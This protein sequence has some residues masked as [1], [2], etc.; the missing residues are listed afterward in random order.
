[1]TV[2]YPRNLLSD[3]TVEATFKLDQG[4]RSARHDSGKRGTFTRVFEPIWTAKFETPALTYAEREAWDAW[5]NSL[6]GG[7][8]KFLAWDTS[9]RELGAYPDGPPT[10][11][12]VSIS[13]FVDRAKITLTALP[14]NYICTV[15]DRI[16]LIKSGR[17]GYFKVMETTTA[18]GSGDAT[19]EVEP[20]V[21][22]LFDTDST[23]VMYRPVMLMT[24]DH[25]SYSS[26]ARVEFT[27]VSF[28]AFQEI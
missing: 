24:M 17:Y 25:E 27:R 19:I 3:R 26:P 10:F 7:L 16:G 1:M 2:S 11:G 22:L 13:A 20:L 6:R 21:P 9:K 12:T 23:V 5:E 28:D 4:V 18:N 15:G 14:A 8:R